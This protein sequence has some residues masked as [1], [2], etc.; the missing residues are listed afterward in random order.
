MKDGGSRDDIYLL[1]KKK[2]KMRSFKVIKGLLLFAFAFTNE[3]KTETQSDWR[4][5][6]IHVSI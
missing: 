5:S 3:S 2:E 4:H 1:S 6:L